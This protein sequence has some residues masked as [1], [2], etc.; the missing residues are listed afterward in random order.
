[1]KKIILGLSDLD[2]IIDE[3]LSTLGYEGVP[4]KDGAIIVYYAP[5]KVYDHVYEKAKEELKK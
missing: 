4:K 2:Y 1:M 3:K 5:E